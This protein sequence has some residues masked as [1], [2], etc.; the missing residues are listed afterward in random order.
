MTNKSRFDAL[1]GRVA[2]M[3]RKALEDDPCCKSYEG[4]WEVT[5]E[6]R[7]WFEDESGSL[8]PKWWCLTLHCYVLGPSRHYNWDGRTFAEAMSKAEYDVSQWEKDLV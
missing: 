1:R 7:D 6:Y 3:I 2:R 4:T 5:V 8:P